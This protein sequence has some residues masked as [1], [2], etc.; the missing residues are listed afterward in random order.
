MWPAVAWVSGLCESIETA[1]L[2][3][4]MRCNPTQVMPRQAPAE[5]GH[6]GNKYFPAGTSV[7]IS[8]F[9]YHRQCEAFGS[10]PDVFRPERWLEASPSQRKAMDKNFLS[11]GGGSRTCIGRSISLL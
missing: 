7:G 3:I 6:I 4:F 5:G 10:D 1:L 9:A 8:A 11:F 2:T